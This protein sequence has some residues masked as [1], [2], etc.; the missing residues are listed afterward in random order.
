MS[1]VWVL[2]TDDD[3]DDDGM[4]ATLHRTESDAYEGLRLNFLNGDVKPGA[5]AKTI[6]EAMQGQPWVNWTITEE[7]L[8]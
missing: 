6:R 8:P 4:V 7:R 5:D 1:T 3:A 2:V